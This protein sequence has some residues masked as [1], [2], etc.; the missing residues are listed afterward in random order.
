MLIK[1]TGVKW[2]ALIQKYYND[3]EYMT[4]SARICYDQK[5]KFP[6]V[7]ERMFSLRKIK[8]V[9]WS[10][11]PKDTLMEWVREYEQSHS[12]LKQQQSD[13]VLK[14]YN[15]MILAELDDSDDE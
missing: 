4:Q 2:D 8:E 11:F 10:A 7:R 12:S 1:E 13:D 5:S 15:T 9:G 14:I 3:I 6:K